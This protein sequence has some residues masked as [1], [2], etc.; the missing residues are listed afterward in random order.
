MPWDCTEKWKYQIGELEANYILDGF[1]ID[2]NDFSKTKRKH[3]KSDWPVS[4]LGDFL[5]NIPILEH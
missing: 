3:N 5:T 2:K 4:T 1:V